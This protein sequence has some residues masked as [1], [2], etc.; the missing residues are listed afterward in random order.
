[1]TASHYN[2]IIQWTASNLNFPDS[3]NS[4]IITKAIFNNYGVPF[5]SGGCENALRTLLSGDYMGWS[6]CSAAQAQEVANQGIA[7][8]GLCNSYVIV[9]KPESKAVIIG[10]TVSNTSSNQ[11]LQTIGEMP[12]EEKRTINFFAYTFIP[13]EEIIN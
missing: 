3:T 8:I 1:M 11:F 10:N 6:A 2:N 7:A 9:I 13:N 5:P 4:Y 12:D